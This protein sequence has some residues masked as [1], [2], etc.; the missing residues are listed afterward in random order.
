MKNFF[1]FSNKNILITGAANGIGKQT[2][3]QLSQAG[4]NL[5]LVDKDEE[6]LKVLIKELNQGVRHFHVDLSNL[7]LI[8]VF[9]TDILSISGPLDGFVNC[10]GI[11]SRKPINMIKPTDVLQIMSINFGSFIE[12]VRI[13]T[14]KGNFNQGLSIVSISSIASLRGNSGVTLYASSK[15]AVNA[16]VRCLAKE[17]APKGI[18]LNTVMPAQID[19]PA[20]RELTQL[21]INQVD[22]TLARQY[23]GLGE[24]TDVANAIMFLL[25]PA[26]RF[27]TGTSLPVD[28][29]Y[30]TS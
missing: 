3:I 22:P 18:R 25:S 1:D 26:S 6:S 30:L 21:N 12:I 19:T 7:D 14:R 10:I 9:L 13:I 28:G 4:A 5:I 29:G 2:A 8:Q 20:F 15:A 24:T 23:L 11:R 16:A 17:L 27:I